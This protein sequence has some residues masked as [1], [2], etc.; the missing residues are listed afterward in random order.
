VTLLTPD[1]GD[2]NGLQITDAIASDDL[3]HAYFISP[4]ALTN[5]AQAGLPN[6][7]DLSGGQ[8]KLVA[9]LSFGDSMGR[10]SRDGRYAILRSTS[11]LGGAPNNG[12]AALYEYDAVNGSL[13]CASC[14]PDGAPSEGDANLGDDQLPGLMQPTFTTT[15]NITDDGAIFFASKDRILRSDLGPAADIYEYH[16]G[17]TTLISSGRS[18]DDAYMADNSDDGRDVFFTTR[19]PLVSSD[20]DGQILDLYDARVGGGFPEPPTSGPGCSDDGCQGPVPARPTLPSIG[21]SAASGHGSLEPPESPSKKTIRL[22]ALSASGLAQL[23]RTGHVTLSIRV[24]G[25]GKLAVR[26]RGAIGGHTR[27]LSTASRTVRRTSAATVHVRLALSRSGRRA[28]TAR[29][30]LKVTIE[31]RL[32]GVSKAQ[33]STIT[34]VAAKR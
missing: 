1:A 16:H 8:T 9:T 4:A 28:L 34:L 6:A 15:R 30:R 32:T 27:T 7:Y 29:R 10:V 20:V 17:T 31:A 23:A 24:S 5:D 19:D 26:I 18:D 13:V 3:S 2:P 11:S 12:K 33:Q 22:T 14:R 21:S 25:G